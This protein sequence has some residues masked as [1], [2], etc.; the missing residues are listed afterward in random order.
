MKGINRSYKIEQKAE[1]LKLGR[2]YLLSL[3]TRRWQTFL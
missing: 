1:R 2:K 3:F